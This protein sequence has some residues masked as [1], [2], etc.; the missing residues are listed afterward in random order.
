MPEDGVPAVGQRRDHVV[1]RELS[2]GVH[3]VDDGFRLV[4]RRTV[5]DAEGAGGIAGF[6]INHVAPDGRVEMGE[7][8]REP[9]RSLVWV[10]GVLWH[11]GNHLAKVAS[12]W[13][14][15]REEER[16]KAG[17]LPSLRRDF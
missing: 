4:V 11:V 3:E 7:G 16:R 2:A 13:G 12:L 14:R 1:A 5:E 17:S 6:Q 15:A 10:G 9:A 8:K